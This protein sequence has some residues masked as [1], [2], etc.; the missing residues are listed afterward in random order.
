MFKKKNLKKIGSIIAL[1]LVIALG[2]AI[3]VGVTS[4]IRSKTETLSP[5][6]FSV[7]DLGES[8]EYIKSEQSLYTKESFNCIGLRI[9]LDFEADMT[10]DVYYYDYDDRFVE[11]RVGLSGVYDED[12]PLAKTC[13]I[14]LHPEVPEDVDAKDFKIN[15]WEVFSYASQC[16]ISIDKKQNYLYTDCINLYDESKVTNGQTFGNTEIG[17]TITLV[18][19][20]DVKVTDKILVSNDYDHFDVFI[21]RNT[22]KSSINTIGVFALDSDNVVIASKAFN[23]EDLDAGEWCRMTFDVPSCEGQMYFRAR[24]PYDAECYIFGYND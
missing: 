10:Y 15:L 12:F 18:E 21:R 7:G 5:F 1:V 14:V 24:L 20:P 9:D 16:K 17:S 6:I 8:G 3:V 2:V 22:H 13:R 19:N 23:L 4:A 11:S